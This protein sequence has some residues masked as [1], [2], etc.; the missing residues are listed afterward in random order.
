MWLKKIILWYD[1][2]RCDVL[3]SSCMISP[4]TMFSSS[5]ERPPRLLTSSATQSPKQRPPSTHRPHQRT[6]LCYSDPARHI[7]EGTAPCPYCLAPCP[8]IQRPARIVYFY[9]FQNVIAVFV[10]SDIRCKNACKM[11][12]DLCPCFHESPTKLCPDLVSF[13]CWIVTKFWSFMCKSVPHLVIRA[14]N[15][16]RF[17]VVCALNCARILVVR[18]L[19][20]AQFL[21][22]PALFPT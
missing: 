15:C 2:C 5:T 20:F 18:A 9:F 17:C 4:T 1:M 22:H 6:T 19:D 13:A 7:S 21:L 3:P 8:I 10:F 14:L 16:A 11:L 12:A